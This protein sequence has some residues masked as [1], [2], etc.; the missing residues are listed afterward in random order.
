MCPQQMQSHTTLQQL[1]F[2][3]SESFEGQVLE[4]SIS[5]VSLQQLELEL[6]PTSILRPKEFLEISTRSNMTFKI[7]TI[8]KIIRLS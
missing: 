3:S 8:T 2:S 5:M 7:F 6:R 4:A 1:D